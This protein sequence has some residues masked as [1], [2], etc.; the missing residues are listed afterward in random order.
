MA[1]KDVPPVIDLLEEE[2]EEEWPDAGAQNPEEAEQYVDKINHIF[3]HLSELIHKD[4]K[5]ALGM[6][7][8]NFKKLVVKQWE[9]MGDAD[10]DVILHTIKDPAAVYLHQHLT[11]G[12]VEVFDPPEEILTG[13]EFIRQLP[14]RTRQ[15]EETAFI[16]EIFDHAAQAHKH[17]SSVCTNISALA[18]ITDKTTLHTIIN[19]AIRPLV[20][21]NILEGFLN[22][23][24]D[25]QPKTTEE[26]RQEKVWKTVLPTSNAP[27]LAHEPKNSPTHILAAAVWLKLNRKYFN[28]GMAKEACDRF[29]VRA[30]QL[31]R[32]L[33]GRKYLGG[34]QA[35]KCK[36][37]EMATT[38]QEPSVQRKRA[39]T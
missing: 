15:A 10:V 25:R 31:S 16:A 17:L 30:K 23:V 37:T 29:E 9:T 13:P 26:E 2:E 36:A 7:I 39:D 4:K 5:D 3:D 19:G 6:T 14:E 33:M 27:C 8:R 11:R 35:R 24:E 28:E 22:P 1:A 34:T 38:A 21:I 32:V 20:Q 18:K 12:G